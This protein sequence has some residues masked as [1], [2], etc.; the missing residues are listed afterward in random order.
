MGAVIGYVVNTL[1]Q[2]CEGVRNIVRRDVLDVVVSGD[3]REGDPAL[4]GATCQCVADDLLIGF[5]AGVIS[6]GPIA[7]IVGREM[8]CHL[9]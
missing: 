7:L 2:L 8:R 9:P 1:T 3:P 4:L 5:C 6:E